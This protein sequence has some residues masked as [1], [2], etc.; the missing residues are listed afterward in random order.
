MIRLQI[1]AGNEGQTW[2]MLMTGRQKAGDLH[3]ARCEMP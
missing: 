2:P 3:Q 1:A